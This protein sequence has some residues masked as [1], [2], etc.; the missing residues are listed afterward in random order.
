LKAITNLHIGIGVAELLAIILIQMSTPDE[1]IG[2]ATGALGLLRSMGGSA[3]TAIYSSILQSKMKELIPANVGAAALKA[4]LP[5]SSLPLL[6][7]ILTGVDTKTAI[8]AV[9]GVTPDITVAATLALKEGYIDSFR[10]IWLSSIAFGVIALA[11]AAATK[12]VS[13]DRV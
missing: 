2:F 9:P 4:G 6:I 13:S 11:C 8:T 5:P 7:E 12:D 3:G 10:Y 1:W